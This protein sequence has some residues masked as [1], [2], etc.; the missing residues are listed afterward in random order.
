[1]NRR[2]FTARAAGTGLGLGLGLIGTAA[3]AQ[4]AQPVEGKDFVRLSSPAP[5]SS[6]GKIEVVEFFWYGCPHCNAFEPALDAWARKLPADVAF[7][8][9]PV[10]FAAMHETHA[11]VF[12]ALEAL[13][14][15][16]AQHRKV[17][18]A[19]HVQHKRLDKEADIVD[20]MVQNGVDGAKFAEAFKSFGVAT[21]VRQGKQLSEAYKIDGVPSIGVAGR[22]YTAPSMAGSPERAL[23]VADALIQ[24]AR[25]PA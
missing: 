3:Q 23:A 25:K 20:F 16:E 5:T 13:G 14:Q 6:N 10:S 22:W 4:G 1:M 19:I 12:Y 21:K 15:V 2:D 24:R 9:V 17:F 8:R 18:A 11:K 7:R